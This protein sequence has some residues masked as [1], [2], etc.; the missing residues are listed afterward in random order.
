MIGEVAL[1]YNHQDLSAPFGTENIRLDNFAV[2]EKVAPNPTFIEQV[3]DKPGYYTTNL[4]SITKT[5]VA[6][7]YQVH[8][9]SPTAVTRHAP[10][11]LTPQWKVEGTQTSVILN[12]SLNPDFFL[13]GGIS[14]VSLT[15]VALIIQLDPAGAKATNARTANGG[16]FARER[17]AVYWR[18]GDVTIAKGAPAQQLRARFFTDGEAKPGPAEARWEIGN[19]HAARLGSGLSVSVL[20]HDASQDESDPFA[21]D[22]A[23]PAEGEKEEVWKGVSSVKRIKSGTTYTAA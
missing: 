10:L 18:L 9:E 20:E 14:S 5:T 21:D 19:E 17:S 3:S 7:K 8:H 11:L 4:S 13:P 1:A 23:A 2:L 6:F 15:N 12:Y 16:N 22:D